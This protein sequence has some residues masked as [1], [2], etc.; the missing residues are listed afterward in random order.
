[1]YLIALEGLDKS[2]KATQVQL[3]QDRLEKGGKKVTTM[4]F[5]RYDTPTGQLIMKWLRREWEVSQETIELIMTADK[6]AQQENF[7]RLEQEGYDFLVLDRYTLSQIV[8]SQAAGIEWL[9]TLALQSHLRQPDLDIYI[10]I[11]P[12]ESMRR[13]GKWGENDRYESDLA[14]LKRVRENYLSYVD[15]IHSTSVAIVDGMA[16]IK[17][18]HEAIWSYVSNEFLH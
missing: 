16:S 5:H 11:T 9:W 8:Y 13:K 14:F 18:V 15:K 6:Q 7:Q 12:E 10:D 2:G 1:M 17:Q 3:L 4:D